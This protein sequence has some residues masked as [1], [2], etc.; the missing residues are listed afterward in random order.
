MFDYRKSAII[1]LR[2]V[3]L[4]TIASAITGGIWASSDW[5]LLYVLV[6]T[7]V[8]PLSVLLIVYGI[9]GTIIAEAPI[10]LLKKQEKR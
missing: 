6:E 1:G 4:L 7:P 10:R 5:L 2:V 3:Q 9:V 8:T